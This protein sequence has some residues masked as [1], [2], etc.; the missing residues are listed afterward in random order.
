M[1]IRMPI[2]DGIEATRLI[3]KMKDTKKNRIPIIATT[4]NALS[5]EKDKCYN[6][7]VDDFLGKPYKPID[8]KNMIE[9]Y[10]DAN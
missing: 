4:A 7:G 9:K 10:V 6:A 1:D 3:R 8:I 2:M 5:E